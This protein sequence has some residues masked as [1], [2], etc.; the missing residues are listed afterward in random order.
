MIIS[1]SRNFIFFKP[2]KVAGSSVEAALSKTC[3]E[4]DIYT[5]SSIK[6][7]ANSIFY[8]SSPKNNWKDGKIL[9]GEEA[10]LYLRRHGYQHLWDESKNHIKLVEPVYTSH[11]SPLMLT[12]KGFSIKDYKTISIVRNPFDSLVSYFWYAFDFSE[13]VLE[14]RYTKKRRDVALRSSLKPLPTD[15]VE[16][17][18]MKLNTF[19]NLPAIFNREDR[20]SNSNQDVFDWFTDWQNEFYEHDLDYVIKFENLQE[21]YEF[22]CREL[23]LRSY[24]LPRFKVSQRK[25]NNNFMELFS[26]RLKDRTKERYLNTF[27]KF[28][29][30]LD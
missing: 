25:S 17:L 20:P 9:E 6:E 19:F 22:V 1:R 7:E 15:S 16:E 5:G 3:A 13:S 27:E 2:I 8:D 24:N 14:S 21:D 11:E 30:D 10:M 23:D 26:E 18:K 29:Y 28:G 4:E 12:G